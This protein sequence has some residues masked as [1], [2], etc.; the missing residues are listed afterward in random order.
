MAYRRFTDSSGI[1]WRVWDVTPL[2]INRRLAI[3][4]I[5]VIRIYHPERRVLPDRRLDMRRSRLYFPPSETGWLC[6]ESA[7]GRHRLRP[8]PPGWVLEPDDELEDLCR[9]A[10][11]ARDHAG[12][13]A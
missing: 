5:K 8:I 3:R 1:T 10:A 4:R 9:L 7:V 6:F 11:E 12:A 13:E 2:R